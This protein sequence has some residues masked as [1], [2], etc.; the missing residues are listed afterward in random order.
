MHRNRII[1]TLPEYQNKLRNG[2]KK[3]GL[4]LQNVE[5][6]KI[7]VFRPV[8]T[9]CWLPEAR[10]KYFN[11]IRSKVETL[12]YSKKFTFATLTYSTRLYSP[13]VCADRV[14]SDI[15]LFF[16][17]LTYRHKR[18]EYF[19][20]LELTKNYMVHIHLMFDRYIP[21]KILKKSWFYVTGCTI[22][23]IRHL[24]TKSAF[25]YCVKYL[26]D[27]KKQDDGKWSFLFSHIDRIW[28]CSRN[29]FAGAVSKEGR[30]KFL[31]CA[32]DPEHVIDSSFENA[33]TD[34]MSNE[35]DYNDAV[36]IAGFSD[37][38]DRLKIMNSAPD[39]FFTSSFDSDINV[40][41]KILITP[42]CFQIMFDFY[43]SK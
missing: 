10:K 21:H 34:L 43:N 31:F 41:K 13:N 29:F 8:P 33:A 35:V 36:L 1:Y 2:Y 11:K 28:T 22:V 32:F 17:R 9:T 7:F 18:P 24:P 42:D 27:C 25:W 40:G 20:V 38:F 5:D 4:F 15:D 3:L 30:Y 19:Y 39:W 12:N 23:D 16:K 6:H 26:S 37:R 14:K